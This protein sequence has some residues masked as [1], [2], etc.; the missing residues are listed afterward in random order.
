MY[1]LC[2]SPLLRH[3]KNK[4]IRN[5]NKL[6]VFSLHALHFKM[7]VSKPKRQH[8]DRTIK[9]KIEILGKLYCGVK[10]VDLCKLHGKNRDA[11]STRW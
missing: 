2:L 5:D 3:E 8:T 10:A 4:C 9:E 6:C 1:L 7:S 11:N